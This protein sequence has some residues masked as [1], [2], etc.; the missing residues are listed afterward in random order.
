MIEHRTLGKSFIYALEGV[1]HALKNNQN[2]R[3]H[4]FTAFLVVLI[5]I[6][7]GVSRLEMAILVVMIL[8]V[9]SAEMINA[10]IEE[11]VDFIVMEHRREAKIAKD[12][13]AGMV[14]I[15]SVGAVIVGLLILA[16]YIIRHFG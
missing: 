3:I 12:V 5:S 7:L 9:I 16:P 15:T 11:M 13:G 2:F 10:S 8:L 1:Y 6:F 4:F 14:L